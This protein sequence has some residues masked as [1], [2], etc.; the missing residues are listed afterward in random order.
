MLDAFII[1]ELKRRERRK[2]EQERPQ[3]ELPLPEP[4]NAPRREGD[5]KP[6]G[7]ARVVVLDL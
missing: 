5:K 7:P 1:E 4:R 3:V 6:S 2:Q